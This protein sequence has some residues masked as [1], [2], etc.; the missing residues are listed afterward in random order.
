MWAFYSGWVDRL[1]DLMLPCICSTHNADLMNDAPVTPA[2][3]VAPDSTRG[4]YEEALAELQTSQR[5]EAKDVIKRR[6]LE[7]RRMEV[8]LEKAK[9]DLAKMLNKDVSE[10]AMLP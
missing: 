3:I 4:I 9:A 6:L 7:I 8:C 5:D 2:E 10:I 1:H